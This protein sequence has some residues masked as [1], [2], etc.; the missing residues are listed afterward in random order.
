MGLIGLMGL[1]SL[2]GLMGWAFGP[3]SLHLNHLHCI[4]AIIDEI[5]VVV[6]LA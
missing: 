6:G 3:A 1:I 5:A 2:M 4:Q